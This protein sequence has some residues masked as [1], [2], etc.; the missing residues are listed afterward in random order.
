MLARKTW[1]FD[2]HDENAS[3]TAAA[4]TVVM[5][6]K[7]MKIETRRY[8]RDTVRRLLAGETKLIAL[9]PENYAPALPAS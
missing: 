5:T 7:Q 4:L 8:I 3:R 6:C 9:L 1:F 2:G